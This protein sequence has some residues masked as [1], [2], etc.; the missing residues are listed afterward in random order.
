MSRERSRP[1]RSSYALG[2]AALA[3]VTAGALAAA[4]VAVAGPGPAAESAGAGHVVATGLNAPRLLSFAPNGALYVAE[5]GAGGHGPCATNGDNAT[6][7]LGMSGSIT[8]IRHG[9]QH[10]IVRHLPSLA[11]DG[12]QPVGPADVMVRHHHMYISMG[13]GIDARARRGL[14]MHGRHLGQLLLSN[15]DHPRHVHV[16]GDAVRFE[17]RH[18][19]DHSVDPQSGKVTRDSDPAGFARTGRT[20]VLAD[21]GGNDLLRIHRDGRVHAMTV[22]PARVVP[23]PPI[24]G[25]PPELPMQAVPTSVVRHHRAFYISQLTG[26]PFPQGG[27]NIYKMRPGHKP[28]VW[29]SGLTNVTDL[30]WHR[31]HLY[32][33]EISAAGL[34]NAPE[35]TMPVGALVRV[36]RGD[37]STP[38]VVAGNLPAPY[39]VALRG[40]SA[41]V[42]TCSVCAGGGQVMRFPIG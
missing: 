25:L 28:H 33:V 3:V 10:R 4:P 27:A 20:F 18:N 30:A 2:A 11:T 31:G 32:A 39:G 15:M 29:A 24:P 35:G 21:A 41:Y 14:G 23:A 5:A 38:D 7:C 26:F 6:V 42:T 8:R 22:F 16:V 17:W 37:N 9:R 12:T 36:H 19:P 34:A 40:G 1:H 13:A